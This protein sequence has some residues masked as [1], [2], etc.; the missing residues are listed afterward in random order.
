MAET[1]KYLPTIPVSHWN[2]LRIQFKRTIP[3]TI[4]SSYLAPILGMTKVS[5]QNN[6]VPSLRQI[7]L[8]NTDGKADQDL[9]NRFRDDSLYPEFC[10]EVLNKVYPRELLEAFS[11]KDDDKVK[12]KSWFMGHSRIG[13]NAAGKMVGFYLALLE[14][15]PNPVVSSSS[16]PKAKEAKSKAAGPAN[17]T[18]VQPEVKE[19]KDPAS[20]P[21]HHHPS[22]SNEPSLNINIQIHISS[23]AS[24]DQIKS[25]FESMAK[26]LYNK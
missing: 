2:A 1:T 20:P 23:D 26:Y 9:I 19:S 17:K 24:P 18:Q 22:Q 13:E 5:A 14:A 6:I 7:G 25:I 15:D 16:T 12:I 21:A 11:S 10:K 8:I 3:T 4:T